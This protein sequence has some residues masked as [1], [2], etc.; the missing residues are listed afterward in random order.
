MKRMFRIGSI[1]L[2]A[3]IGS[4]G[5]SQMMGGLMIP[6]LESQYP[7]GSVFCASGP[8]AI[9]EVTNP[10]TGKVWMDRNMG[11]S[12]AATSSTDAAAYGDLYQWGRRSDGHQCRTS[13]T[14]TTLSSAD[15][16]AH[17]NFIL[18]PTTPF[19]WRSPQNTNLWQGVNGVN[20]PCPNGY[21]VPSEAELELERTSW[22]T[23]N[24]SGA[25]SSPLKLTMSG[26]RDGSNG[27]F[28]N[29]G[30]NGDYWS[31][32]IS[33][34]GS[35]SLYFPVNNAGMNTYNRVNG[36]SIRC[37]K[38]VSATLGAL[39]CGSAATTGTLT[40]GQPASGVSTS[41]PYTGGNGGSYSAQA[42]SSTGVTGLTAN[43]AAGEVN[44]GS[45]N[46]VYTI[47]GTPSAA[48]TASFAISLGGQ[49]CTL[50]IIVNA[51]TPV[52]CSGTATVL[53]DVTNP[54]TGKIWMDRN[55]GASRAAISVTDAQS[56]GDL[57]QWGRRSDGH[58]CRNSASTA[59]TSS[60]DQPGHGDFILSS[61]WRTPSNPNLWQGVNG[62]NN[63]CP[64]G[65]RLPSRSEV[66]EE[67]SS[68]SSNTISGAFSSPLKFTVGGYRANLLENVG[69]YGF[70]WTSDTS[71]INSYSSYIL[72]ILDSGGNTQS[73]FNRGTGASVRCIKN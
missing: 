71:P 44:N 57:Y 36:E 64:S 49:S 27:S 12:Q 65:Y 38:E 30:S 8:T 4:H 28:T 56:Y 22:S 24:A 25:F 46:L 54:T 67:I 55:L 33:G 1:L 59:T 47:T 63:P 35:R 9:V 19:D 15:Q 10:T 13:P 72:R 29:V 42:V 62:V 21:R 40:E 50:E 2:F 16:P 43:L 70:Y 3:S 66:N 20:N 53:V 61:D 31:S 73:A 34:N 69:L 18:A 5:F 14:T 37:I 41:G 45:G 68:W 23:N 32:T 58:Q 39:N 17:G 6:S 51:P 60:T 7:T 48:G 52:Y 26:G 11:A